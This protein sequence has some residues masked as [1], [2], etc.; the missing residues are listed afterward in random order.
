MTWR[1]KILISLLAL[2]LL[3]LWAVKAFGQN[4]SDFLFWHEM[5]HQRERLL[6]ELNLEE[7]LRN[8]RPSKNQSV[9]DLASDAQAVISILIKEDGQEKILL[10][11][12]SQEVL[13]IASLTKLMTAWVVLQYYDLNEEITLSA[14]SAN[15]YGELGKLQAGDSFSTKYLLYPLLM[16]S[17]NGAAM[18]LAQ[19]YPGMTLENFTG[20]MNME[21]EKIGLTNTFFD[22]PSGLDPEE[23][24][25]RIN[26]SSAA[27]LATL[28]KELL[29]EPLIW[30]I[31]SLPR[32][33]LYGPELINTN[34]LLLDGTA[35][36]QNRII[37]GKT[38][39]TE[40]AGGCFLLAVKAPKG[41]GT[42]INIILGANGREN[43]FDE[44]KKLVDWL[45]ISYKW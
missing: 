25:T 18:A 17:S 32:Y 43:R 7:Q 42:L 9:A 1:K 21:A 44:M 33:S 31:L 41:Q 13:P 19:D 14:L 2:I 12:N 20:L 10:E 15:Q 28:T 23:S 27:D 16:E 26:Y 37:G 6:T 29:S 4:I 38:G 40:K 5:S 3:S 39:Y 8:L 24:K 45:K 11:N 30:E 22:N 35:Y 34:R 36:W